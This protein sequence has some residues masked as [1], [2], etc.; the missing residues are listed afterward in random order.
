MAS[1]HNPNREV[2]QIEILIQIEKDKNR[3]YSNITLILNHK[4]FLDLAPF[5]FSIHDF[6]SVR[7]LFFFDIR[8]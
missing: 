2:S 3:N 8:A 6:L 1:N 4:E 7:V 5:L